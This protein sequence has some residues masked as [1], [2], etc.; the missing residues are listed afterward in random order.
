M[1]GDLINR[2]D[3]VGDAAIMQRPHLGGAVSGF[4]SADQHDE[5]DAFVVDIS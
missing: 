5:G 1:V 4:F 3:D 2:Q